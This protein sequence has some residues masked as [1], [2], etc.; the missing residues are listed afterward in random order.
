MSCLELALVALLHCCIVALIVALLHCCCDLEQLSMPCGV[1]FS[2][3]LSGLSENLKKL[4]SPGSA[5]STKIVYDNFNLIA[6]NSCKYNIDV[7][8]RSFNKGTATLQ[9]PLMTVNLD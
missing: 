7:H 2:P 6:Q 1:G 4:V 5:K 8:E 9:R 3:L